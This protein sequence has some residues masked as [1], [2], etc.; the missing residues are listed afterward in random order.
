M[1]PKEN[2]SIV[3]VFYRLFVQILT[4]LWPFLGRT[5]E[6]YDMSDGKVSGSEPGPEILIRPIPTRPF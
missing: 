2:S 5:S 3:V 6:I 1:F 4:F